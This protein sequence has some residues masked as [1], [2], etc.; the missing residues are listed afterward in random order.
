MAIVAWAA[1]SD[2][3]SLSDAT[4]GTL[5]APPQ[6]GDAGI[7]YSCPKTIEAYCV[8]P[9]MCI[10]NWSDVPTCGGPLDGTE[11]CGTFKAFVMG[12]V[13][14]SHTYY[15][16]AD[17]HLVGIISFVLGHLNCTAG[18]SPFVAPQCGDETLLPHCDGGP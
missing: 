17:G 10:R 14:T 3:S 4:P 6:V 15:Y 18:P 7:T 16:D 11:T 12:G 1:C 8:P 2:S 13:D 9:V 5:D